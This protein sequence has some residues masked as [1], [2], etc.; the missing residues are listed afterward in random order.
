MNWKKH[1]KNLLVFI[2]TL[3]AV[4]LGGLI[5]F[6]FIR[7]F[8]PFVIGWLI[9]LI[10]NP[11]VRMLERRMKVARKHTS[12]LLIIAV[13][14]AIIGGIYFIGMKT[15]QEAS[16]LIEQAPEI[17]SSFREDFQEAGENLS[18]IIEELPDG[19]Q[20]GIADFQDSLGNMIGT[21]VGKISQITVDQASNFA[22]NLPSIIIAIIFTI[23]SSYFF[24]ADRDKILEFGREH[25]PQLIQEKW[26]ILERCFRSIFG[27]YFKAQFKIMGVVFVILCI[28]FLI[29]KV[30]FAIV[31]AF[32]VSFLDMLPFFGTGTALIPWA[33]FKILSGDMQY[34]VGLIILYLT[35]Q[36]I[37]RIIEPKVVGDSIGIDP[38]WTLICM[39]TG[40]RFAGVLGMILAVPVG[41]IIVNFYHAGMFNSA[42]RNLQDAVEDFL[43][44]L[45]RDDGKHISDNNKKE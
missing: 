37:R 29:L 10:A 15:L 4:V 30:N 28:G 21:A 42:I 32:L 27:G 41:A 26:K 1:I 6:K 13:L 44:W 8:M 20:K 45:Y 23:L 3:L 7:F 19:V 16:S 34:A 39:Y 9:A 12:M 2:F 31:V 36:L 40:Y 25:T 24:I 17:Y 43:K 22:K 38:L 35:T 11:L 33:L 5:A 14:A 18:M